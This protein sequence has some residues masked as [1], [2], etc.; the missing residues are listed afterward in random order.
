MWY[1]NNDSRY[2]IFRISSNVEDSVFVTIFFLF[3]FLFFNPDYSKTGEL[4][5]G[6]NHF[7]DT[8]NWKQTFNIFT[9][10]H[11]N[12]W[13]YR[14]IRFHEKGKVLKKATNDIL[15]WLPTCRSSRFERNSSGS[16]LS[17]CSSISLESFRD[18]SVIEQN[19]DKGCDNG[20]SLFDR[21]LSIFPSSLEHNA[22]CI[23]R[24]IESSSLSEPIELSSWLDISASTD[25]YFPRRPALDAFTNE[26]GYSESLILT[27]S[28]NQKGIDLQ[29]YTFY[30]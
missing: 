14:L 19:N 8:N 12:N 27:R 23:L 24:S 2:V 9:E 4:S 30:F 18:D 7:D 11:R 13:E 5:R 16:S 22:A 17:S 6:I 25:V 21:R 20:L 26:R 15:K 28:A 1:S 10:I 3:L 29:Q